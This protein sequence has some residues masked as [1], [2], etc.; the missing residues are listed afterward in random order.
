MATNHGRSS[1]SRSS[2][3]GSSTAA[4]CSAPQLWQG[5][6]YSIY[7]PSDDWIQTV[8]KICEKDRRGEEEME[9]KKKKCECSGTHSDR[10]YRHGGNEAFYTSCLWSQQWCF[11][12]IVRALFEVQAHL[13][14]DKWQRCSL[15]CAL[16]KKKPQWNIFYFVLSHTCFIRLSQH[17]SQ[18]VHIMPH[19][20]N[21]QRVDFASSWSWTSV[22]E[23]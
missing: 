8:N 17:F 3:G 11:D 15:F 2:G 5:A 20:G 9:R 22:F 18:A 19:N 6:R 4:A 16:E 14:S 1:S 23:P 13:F 7:L 21:E 10:T 12:C